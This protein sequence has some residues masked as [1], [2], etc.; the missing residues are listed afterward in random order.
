LAATATV[1]LVVGARLQL[2]YGRQV[3]GLVPGILLAAV[4][5]SFLTFAVVLGS[6]AFGGRAV[7][8]PALGLVGGAVLV[9]WLA[10][11]LIAGAARYGRLM[12]N[13][14]PATMTIQAVDV[15]RL[16]NF[17]RTAWR[18]QVTLSQ[19]DGQATQ[20]TTA[21]S[22]PTGRRRQLIQPGVALDVRTDR[23]R[24]YATII[25]PQTASIR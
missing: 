14:L 23:R 25:W 10:A 5:C 13:G 20:H 24:R 19:P 22:Q 11:P 15:P 8:G 3:W 2:L 16:L 6:A 12:R 18:L 1:L 17:T 9:T 7:V 4:G 21:I